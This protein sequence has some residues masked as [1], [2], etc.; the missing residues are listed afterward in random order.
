MHN[1]QIQDPFIESI[2]KTKFDNDT[3]K[4]FNAV[5]SFFKKENNQEYRLLKSYQDGILSIG[6]I[7]KILDMSKS[8]V[9]DLLEKHDIGFITVDEEYLEQEFNA[10]KKM[11]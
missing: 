7:A 9:M 8:E 1:L 11:S 3:T 6:Q 10:F 5:K 4:F 2:L